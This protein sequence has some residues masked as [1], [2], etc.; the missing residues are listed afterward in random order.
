MPT[1]FYDV[2]VIGRS[3]GALAAAAMLARRDF[4]VLVVGQ[5]RPTARYSLE[6]FTLARRTFSML[7]GSSS[8]WQRIMRELAHTQTWRRRAV[9]VDPSLQ[10]LLTTGRL[11]VPADKELFARELEREAFDVRRQVAALYDDVAR[12]ANAAD[13]CFDADAI[14]PPASFFERRETM[15]HVARVPY[16]RSEPHADLLAEFPRG[17]VYRR[18]V[19]ESVRFATDLA[20]TPPAMATARLHASWTRGL[21]ALPGGEDELEEL[22]VERIRANGGELLLGERV[23]R[24]SVKGGAANGVV[25]DGEASAIGA[26]HVVTD[27][28]GEE[29]VRLSQGE[30]IKKSAQREWPRVMPSTGRFV[31]SL[32]V[33]REGVPRPLGREALLIPGDAGAGLGAR[34]IHLQRCDAGDPRHLLLVAELLLGEREAMALLEARRHVIAR[35]AHE[36][37]HLR[38]HL[39]WVDSPHD[40]LPAWRYEGGDVAELER[41]SVGLSARA[42]PMARQ[43]EVDPPGFLGVAGEPL[44]GPIERTLLVGPSVLPALG[45]EG[46][47]LAASSAARLITRSDRRKARMR[48]ETWTKLE[49]E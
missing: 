2:I 17:H 35:L 10:L 33:R 16:A 5:G 9:A 27:A 47:L 25:L 1:K 34:A 19:A 31:T 18:I 41:S 39:V 46:V 45:Q 21:V 8:V 29:L 28:I 32:V 22:L 48:R 30:G 24:I 36:L 43:I 38:A 20:G 26:G 15:R 23:A 3:L 6:G 42:E 13:V 4:T 40:G 44:R 14:W 12:V 11:D 49:V 37:P 7:A